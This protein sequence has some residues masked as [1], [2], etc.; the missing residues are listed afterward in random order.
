MDRRSAIT[1]ASLVN[2][3]EEE[4]LANLLFE[5]GE[6]RLSRRIARAIVS[7]RPLHTTAELAN[8]VAGVVPRRGRLHPATRTFQALRIGTNDELNALSRGLEGALEVLAEGGRLAVIAFHS[9]EDRLVKRRFLQASTLVKG[10]LNMP[11]LSLVTRHPIQPSRAE[12]LRNPRSR[13]AKLRVVE[14]TRPRTQPGE[15]VH[16]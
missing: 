13:S 7:A 5:L 3:L 16:A 4:E 12:Q 14:K 10:G 11:T 8:V 15:V 2:E 6:E 1:A 9:L